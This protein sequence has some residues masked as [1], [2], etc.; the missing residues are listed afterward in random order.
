MNSQERRIERYRIVYVWKI[1]EGF[2]PNCGVELIQENQRLGR[3]CKVPK[4]AQNGGQSVQTLREQS[5]QINGVR[6]FNRL[7]KYLRNM[8]S[9]QEDFKAELDKFICQIPDQPRIGNLIPKAVCR[10]T[11][12][13]SK[14]LL[15]WTYTII[16]DL[17]C[18]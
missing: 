5:F 9:N 10:N 18:P 11:V 16:T 7:P 17:G 14:S 4:L 2:A 15:A 3:R 1:L 12:R 6:L 13:Q 8:T